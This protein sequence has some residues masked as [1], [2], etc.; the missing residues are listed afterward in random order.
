ME[1]SEKAT[2]HYKWVPPP[3][4]SKTRVHNKSLLGQYLA[5]C[6]LIYIE[7]SPI[8]QNQIKK[9]EM[10]QSGLA[11]KKR[12]KKQQQELR[13]IGIAAK[14]TPADPTIH[15]K[16]W[17]ARLVGYRNFNGTPGLMFKYVG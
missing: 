10:T 11:Q 17:M 2:S 9:K 16:L 3:Q 14:E 1:V 5:H 12:K 6:L 7:V 8:E 4:H 15:S 13:G